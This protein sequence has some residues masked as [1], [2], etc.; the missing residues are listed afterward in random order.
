[1][2]NFYD[3]YTMLKF[4]YALTILEF[5]DITLGT[6]HQD[7]G[8]IDGFV[9]TT[10]LRQDVPNPYVM[11]RNDHTQSQHPDVQHSH[12]APDL[13]HHIAFINHNP[14]LN[15]NLNDPP[16][17]LMSMQLSTDPLLTPI[18]QSLVPYTHP[19]P[20]AQE[21][22]HHVA[23]LNKSLMSH[24]EQI[25]NRFLMNYSE[26]TNATSSIWMI[27]TSHKPST[28]PITHWILAR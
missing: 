5:T 16:T 21:H 4:S 23:D 3:V 24:I 12:V 13:C 10:T 20:D 26:S 17:A 15:L 27:Q 6:P 9:I 18:A 7:S 28:T 25:N 2:S 22:C 19:T 14:N 11:V 1:M 8:T